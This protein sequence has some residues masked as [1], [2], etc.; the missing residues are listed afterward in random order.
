M[1][2]ILL[3]C[4]GLFLFSLQAYTQNDTITTE[5]GLKYY[6]INKGDGP[7]A[8][9]GWL[10]LTHYTGTFEDGSIF[11]SSRDR[12]QLFVFGLNKGQVIKGMD[13]AVSL[14]KVGD[15]LM[16]IIPSELAYGEKGAGEVIPPNTTIIFDV[17]LVDMMENS[18]GMALNDA[19]H[20]KKNGEE[21]STLYFKDMYKV[22]KKLKKEDFEGYYRSESDLN[23]IGYSVIESN[24]KEAIK[25]FKMNVE[26][27]P[28]SFN[29]YD[30]LGEAYMINGDTKKAIANYE[31]SLE[32]DPENTNARAMI[33][34]MESE[35]K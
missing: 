28:E 17:E 8:K 18:V 21:D 23:G 30:S 34:K 3:F 9:S 2:S 19:L 25:I 13:E 29:V 31:R 32:L 6:Y 15:R 1:K 27:Y 14:M 16:I 4:L 22:F 10:M 33:K 24:T 35:G 12:N 7:K 26:L 5:S 11:D 20:A